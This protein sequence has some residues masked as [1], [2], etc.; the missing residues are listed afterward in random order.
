MKFIRQFLHRLFQSRVPTGPGNDAIAYI[1]LAYQDMLIQHKLH[2]TSW[3]FGKEKAWTADLGA[4]VIMFTFEGGHTGTAHFQ[5]IGIF[6]EKETSFTWGWALDSVPSSLSKHAKLAK[7]WG[8][9]HQHPAF[10]QQT[11]QCDMEQAWNFAA[12]ARKVA[13]ANSVYRGRIGD[14]FIF[15]T[16][17]EIHLDMGAS[18]KHW[19]ESRRQASW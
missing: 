17:D 18:K 1:A 8:R 12:V 11:V 14:S 6:K 13:N 3:K 9:Q 2:A 19:S 4:G 5:T 16:T 15:M 10:L 7:K